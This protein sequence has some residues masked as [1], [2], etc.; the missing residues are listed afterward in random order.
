M[1]HKILDRGEAGDNL[2]ALVR[3]VKR[4]DVRRG[5][6]LCAPG[7]VKSHTKFE[8]QVCLFACVEQ[9]DF[10]FFSESQF[11]FPL[12]ECKCTHWLANW[13]SSHFLKQLVVCLEFPH[14]LQRLHAYFS[15]VI[16]SLHGVLV[17]ISRMTE[18]CSSSVFVLAPLNT[19]SNVDHFKRGRP[20]F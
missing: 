1:F 7:T 2:G 10:K 16:D 20:R 8:A 4:E 13:N 17:C 5:M 18:R 3:G 6:V 9:S 14:S 11:G 15:L 12:I 19:L